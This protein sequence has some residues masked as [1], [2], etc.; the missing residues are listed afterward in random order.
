M[1]GDDNPKLAY[2]ALT[3]AKSNLYPRVLAT[4]LITEANKYFH[5]E[6]ENFLFRFPKP[7]Q[8]KLED[9]KKLTNEVQDGDDPEIPF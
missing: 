1:L 8:R 5:A 9:D 3:R 7:K 2:V 6:L 4:G